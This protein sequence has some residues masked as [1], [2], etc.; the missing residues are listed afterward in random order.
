MKDFEESTLWRVSEF[1]REQ[2][3]TGG[4][5][6]NRLDQAT[7]LPSTLLADLRRLDAGGASNDPLE[8]FAACIRH[9]EAALLC[10]QCAGL[11]WPLTLFPLQMLHHSPR[12]MTQ[13][14][15]AALAR[16]TLLS[17]EPPGVR[18]PGHWMHE[19][20]ADA[21]QYR[22]LQPLLWSLAIDGPRGSLLA[23]I[24]GPM[25]YRAIKNVED[26]GLPLGGALRSA[27]QRLR[28]ETV[29]LR[30]MASWPGMS[31]ERASR[32]LNA[33][34]LSS[35]LLVSRS[36]PAARGGLRALLGGGKRRV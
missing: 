9:R 27:A 26:E 8:V 4:S 18:P 25:G 36:H 21:A 7:V 1:E 13:M 34:Y 17:T 35:A 22:P 33:L 2:L 5:A 29:S 32:L 10:L 28:R 12:D 31:T 19:R 16:A 24:E 30:E 3:R 15:P 11:V 6:F 20:I 23:E 14:L